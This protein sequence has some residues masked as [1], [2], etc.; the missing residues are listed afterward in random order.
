MDSSRYGHEPRLLSRP[1]HQRL[2]ARPANPWATTDATDR[3]ERHAGRNN[4]PRELVTATMSDVT[5]TRNAEQSRYEAHIDGELAGF[6]HYTQ[7]D[8]VVVMDHT[9]TEDGFTGRGVASQ[10]VKYALGDLARQGATVRPTCPFVAS[11]LDKHPDHPITVQQ[12]GHG[13]QG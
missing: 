13:Q 6:T 8:D 4:P 1:I 12:G 7:Q 3:R 11:W 5:V 9:E 2:A 10:V